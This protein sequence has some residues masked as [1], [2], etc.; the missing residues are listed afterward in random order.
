MHRIDEIIDF[1]KEESGNDKVY[2]ETDIFDDLEM[3]GDDFHE[4]IENYSKRFDVK[5]DNYLWYFHSNDEGIGNIGAIFFTPPFKKV[6]RIPISPNL[7]LNCANSR[8]WNVKYPEHNGQV[9]RSDLAVNRILAIVF[10]CGFLIY[11]GF[12]LLNK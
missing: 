9:G 4:M 10:I 1:I 3:V 8:Q 12:K 11:Y 7:L 6:E 2:P 5:M